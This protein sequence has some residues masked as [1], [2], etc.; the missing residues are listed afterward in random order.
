MEKSKWLIRLLVLLLFFLINKHAGYGQTIVDKF[1]PLI[2]QGEFTQA[3]TAMRHELAENLSLSSSDRLALAFEL[4][5]LDRIR[6]DFTATAEEV[7]QFIQK[8]I[9]EVSETDL[10]RW[11]KQKSLEVM[12]IDGHKCYFKHATANL[13]RI[14]ATARKRK[15]EYHQRNRI[16]TS[17]G[18]AYEKHAQQIIAASQKS[19]VKWVEPKRFRITYTLTVKPDQVPDGEVIR[20]WLPYPREGNR[21]QGSIELHRTSPAQ[22][23]IAD[24]ERF[25]QRTLYLEQTSQSGQ[26][27]TFAYSVSFTTYAE[28]QGI[29]PTQVQ[30][31]DTRSALYRHYTR[32]QPP[33]IVFTPELRT[34]SKQIIGDESNPYLKAKK[35][36]TWVDGQVPWASAREYSTIRNLSLYAYEN[37]HGDCGMQTLLFMTL[38]RM[39]GIPVHWQ[40]G[41]DLKPQEE[42][43]HD[44][45]EM[46]LEPYGWVLVDQSYGIKHSSDER[47][48]WF[49]LGSADAYRWIVNDDFSQP[50][51]PLKIFPRSE[52]VDFQRGEVEWR[53]GNLYFDAWDYSWNIERLD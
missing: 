9:P 19:G 13:F 21:R 35:I 7:K 6:K 30:P 20:A 37:K 16:A 18:F 52:T 23:L 25:K 44:W 34:L 8:Y 36:F 2:E 27:T 29:E 4:E 31:Y 43:L 46:Y 49:C 45:C 51:F 47:V 41:F 14:D 40:S 26:P 11:E 39:N 38:A 53:G 24:N 17:A 32:E 5:R 15:L 42:N 1:N 12:T 22:H 3:Q 28:Y 33:H 50:L 10:A 48:K